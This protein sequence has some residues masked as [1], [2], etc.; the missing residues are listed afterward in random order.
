MVEGRAEGV[1]AGPDCAGSM[2]EGYGVGEEGA[3][4]WGRSMG[5]GGGSAGEGG[6]AA[7]SCVWV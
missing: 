3:C 1:V 5:E 2:V 7:I 4:L 6:G